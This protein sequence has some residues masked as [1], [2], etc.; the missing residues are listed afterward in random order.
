MCNEKWANLSN[1]FLETTRMI[2]MSLIK[3]SCNELTDI[4]N[5]GIPEED[6]C[7]SIEGEI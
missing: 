4:V 5:S 6:D 2:N 3:V 1:E 7:A